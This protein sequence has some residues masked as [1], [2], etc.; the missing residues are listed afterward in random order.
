[1]PVAVF[2]VEPDALQLVW[3]RLPVR[4]MVV[5]VGGRSFP[6]GGPPPHWYPAADSRAGGPGAIVV[7]GLGPAT[8][9]DVTVVAEGRPRVLAATARTAPPP[10]GRPLVRFATLSDC[11]IG[12]RH[13]GAVGRIRDPGSAIAGLD[14]YPLRALKAARDEALSWGAEHLVVRGDLTRQGGTVD[15]LRVARELVRSGLPVYAVLGNHDVAGSS[16]VAAVLRQAGLTVGTSAEAAAAD[17]PGF[18]L[19]LGHSPVRGLHGGR[20][21]PEHLDHLVDLVGGAPGPAVLVMHHPPRAGG[22]PTYYPPVLSAADS[23]QLVRRVVDA[24]PAV[25]VLSGHT[26]RTRRYDL[27]GLAVS[28]VGSTKDYP[29]QWAGYTVYE[30][31][32]TQTARRIAAP[33]VIAWT[34]MTGRALGGQWA[35]WS[36]GRLSDRNW[37]HE[38]PSGREGS[39]GCRG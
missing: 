35:R 26:H 13:F 34:E 3:G 19:V 18:R 17:L 22:P 30:G 28:E 8:N 11:H 20:L 29:G 23:R 15:A 39:A 27:G 4:E 38:W 31:G 1:M 6:I 7:D 12:E 25:M 36:P 5:E 10:P 33:D 14:P 37:V 2:G 9:Y 21:A 24:N 32:I 16:D